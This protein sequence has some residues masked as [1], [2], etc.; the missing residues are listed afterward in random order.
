M[1]NK[2]RA[3]V[4]AFLV[5]MP[6]EARERIRRAAAALGLPAQAWAREVLVREAEQILE[7]E[8]GRPD[9]G[10]VGVVACGDRLGP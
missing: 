5:R 4:V 3:G 1:P 6:A 8:G 2:R 9:A 7:R 10:S